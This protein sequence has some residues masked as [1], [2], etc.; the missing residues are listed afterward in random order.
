MLNNKWC[1]DPLSKAKDK[2]RLCPPWA[3]QSRAVVASAEGAS[4]QIR[5]A[6]VR[7]AAATHRVDVMEGE[8]WTCV[9]TSAVAGSGRRTCCAEGG[10]RMGPRRIRSAGGP[11][12][13]L[14][15]TFICHVNRPSNIQVDD[16][17]FAGLCGGCSPRLAGIRARL[18]NLNFVPFLMKYG[19]TTRWQKKK[20]KGRLCCPWNTQTWCGWSYSCVTWLGNHHW[21]KIAKWNRIVKA[22]QKGER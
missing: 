14:V 6:A 2:G 11:A 17:S 8:E 19:H 7:F 3:L 18:C 1:R 4:W 21:H 22:K 20:N 9:R 12:S 16:R 13:T 10:G 15:A 5:K